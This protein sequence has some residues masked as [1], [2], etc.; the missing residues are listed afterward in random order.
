MVTVVLSEGCLNSCS[1]SVA[2]TLDSTE[3]PSGTLQVDICFESDNTICLKGS[4][5]R[6]KPLNK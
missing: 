4:P 2:S 6:A 5:V 1:I 3:L